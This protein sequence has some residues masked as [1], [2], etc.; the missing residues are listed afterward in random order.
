VLLA[1]APPALAA[2]HQPG[3]DGALAEDIQVLADVIRVIQ[4]RPLLRANRVEV[5]TLFGLGLSDTMFRHMAPVLNLRFHIDERWSVGASG[6]YYFPDTHGHDIPLSSTST[7][8]EAVTD[9]FEVFPEKAVIEWSAGVDTSFIPID[10][11][12]ALFNSHI[13][14]F[15]F[16]L[17]AGGGVLQTSRSG[18]LKPAGMVGLG[19]R[20]TFNR[21]LAL[22][23]EF[24]DHLYMENYNAGD[25]FVN[26]VMFQTG[27][28]WWFP[29]DFEYRFPR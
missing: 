24:R 1:L 19:W 25:E 5:Q 9:T 27:L 17:L 20:L 23:V 4:Q 8:F 18:S 2:P 28:S 14:Y 10:G 15:D 7:I 3:V 13:L 16:Y 12:F 21:W 22:T 26:H 29:F 6:A 11:K